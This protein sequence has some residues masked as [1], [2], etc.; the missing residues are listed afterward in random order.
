MQYILFNI[1]IMNIIGHNLTHRRKVRLIENSK[2]LSIAGL[3]S[4]D[5]LYFVH[6]IKYINNR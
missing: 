1:N 4:F 3:T 2:G 5:K 6:L